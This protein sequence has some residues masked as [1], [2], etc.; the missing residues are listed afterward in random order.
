MK[1]LVRG[2]L[3]AIGILFLGIIAAIGVHK[4]FEHIDALANDGIVVEEQAEEFLDD[5]ENWSIEDHLIFRQ[6]VKEANRVDSMYLTIPD[7]A[8]IAI[9]TNHGTDLSNHEIVYIYESNKLTYDN[10]NLGKEMKNNLDSLYKKKYLEYRNEILHS[11]EI[12]KRE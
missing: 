6:E 3:A 7:E 5:T 4:T 11:P 1:A 12:I 9:L 2:F 10:I 8:L